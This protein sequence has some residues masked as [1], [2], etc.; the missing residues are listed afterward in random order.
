M[1]FSGD[2]Q[3]HSLNVIFPTAAEASAHFR[4]VETPIT[5]SLSRVSTEPAIGLEHAAY[6]LDTGENIF[7]IDCPVVFDSQQGRRFARVCGW[8]YVMD[9]GVWREEFK[10][11]LETSGAL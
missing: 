1:R 5:E 4:V 9:F 7:L 6:R 2:S 3:N 10:R 11:L 8:H